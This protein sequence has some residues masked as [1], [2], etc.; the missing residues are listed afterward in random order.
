MTPAERFARL[1]D[2]L[3]AD[4]ELRGRGRWVKGTFS[5]F[6]GSTIEYILQE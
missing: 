5:A 6:D 3:A 1:P 4:T 2:L